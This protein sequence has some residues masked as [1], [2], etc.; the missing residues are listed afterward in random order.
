[1]TIRFT[2]NLRDEPLRITANV[3]LD[4][5]DGNGYQRGLYVEDVRAKDGLDRDVRLTRAEIGLLG[6]EAVELATQMR[7]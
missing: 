4:S 2:S 7:V 6:E 1:M 3:S 5:M